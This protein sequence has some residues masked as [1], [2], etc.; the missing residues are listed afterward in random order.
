MKVLNQIARAIIVGIVRFYQV[1]IS[2]WLGKSCRYSPT[3]SQYMIEAV[4]EWGALKGFWMGL[5]RVG[6]CHPWGGHGYDPVPE[7]PDKKLKS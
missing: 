6:R 4:N 5:K 1:A 3:C 7:N 2:P